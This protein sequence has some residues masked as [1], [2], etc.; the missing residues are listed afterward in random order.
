MGKLYRKLRDEIRKAKGQLE[1]SLARDVRDNRKG[2]CR[3]VA[4]RRKSWDNEGP[5]RE[6]GSCRKSVFCFAIPQFY[7]GIL[8]NNGGW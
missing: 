4:N 1:P 6:L 7:D 3:R 2:F 5:L 8:H